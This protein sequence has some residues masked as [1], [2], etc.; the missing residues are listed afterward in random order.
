MEST[1]KEQP[2]SETQVDIRPPSSLWR[3]AWIRL[4]KNKMALMGLW[5]LILLILFALSAPIIASRT[6]AYD[7][8]DLSMTSAPPSGRHW[9]G[10]DVLGRDLAIRI[11]YGAQVSLAVGLAATIVAI[12]IGVLYGS[13]AGFIGGKLDSMMM[14]FVDIMYSLPFTIFVILLMVFY[15]RKF[16]NLFLAIGAVEWL[17]M[18]R[19][20]RGQMLSLKRQEFVEAAFALGLRRRR[21]I[22]RHIIPNMLG[23]IIIYATLSVPSIMLLEAFLS[24]LGLGIQPPM[25]SLGVLIE[26]GARNMEESPWMLVFPAAVFSLT[27]FSLNFLGDGLRDALDPR[28]SKD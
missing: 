27:L 7:K 14:R 2:A 22:L 11:L 21:I 12:T 19:V 16:V 28:A 10:T 3:D 17:T 13:I 18:A 8:Q 5:F 25:C 1:L 9:L 15:G 4:S 26:E 20:V 6:Y 24:F 23:I